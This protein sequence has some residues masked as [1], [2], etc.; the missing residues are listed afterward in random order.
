[1][2]SAFGTAGIATPAI[3][4]LLVSVLYVRWRNRGLGSWVLVFV[5]SLIGALATRML[6][7]GVVFVFLHRLGAS[8]L[9]LVDFFAAEIATSGI[10]AVV[11]C[12]II[13][14]GR[15][16]ALPKFT[17][18]LG[19]AVIAVEASLFAW[20]AAGARGRDLAVLGMGLFFYGLITLAGLVLVAFLETVV[21]TVFARG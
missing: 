17:L 16:S 7:S 14:R 19:A 6:L 21:R 10:G 8:G 9:L 1:M 2:G 18:W 12:S 4:A 11:G 20:M 15:G 3:V 13:E 5:T